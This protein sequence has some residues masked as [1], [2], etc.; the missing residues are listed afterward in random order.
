MKGS[1][2]KTKET[3]GAG[4]KAKKPGLSMLST[5]PTNQAGWCA[6]PFS[7]EQLEKRMRAKAKLNEIEEL[8]RKKPGNK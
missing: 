7:P 8:K 5:C 2:T 1:S 6:Y 4:K 3:T